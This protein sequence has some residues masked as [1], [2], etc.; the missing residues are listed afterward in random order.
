MLF[1]RDEIPSGARADCT[2]C[3]AGLYRNIPNSLD[4]SLALYISTVIFMAIANFYPFITM[5]TAGIKA[6]T[7]VV[8]GGYALYQFGMGELG[9]VV[10]LTSIIFPLVC[11]LGMIY[12]LLPARFGSLPPFYGPVYRIVHACEPWSLL[13]VFMLGTLIAAVKLRAL[14][15]V[16]PG[17]GMFGFVMMLLT[18]SAARA[19]FDPE[20][21]WSKCKVKQLNAN[22]FS[23]ETG[24]RVLNC[25]TCG[26]LREDHEHLHECERCGA[27]MH[28]R[29]TDSLQKTWAL[30]LAATVMLIPAQLFPVMSIKKLGKGGADTI[31]SGVIHLIEG[32]LY[33][34]AFIVLFASLVVPL[35]KLT[36][37][38]YLLYSVRNKSDW[39]PRDRTQLYR[40]TEIV[41][42]WSMVDVFLVGL[43]S[44]LVSLGLLASI[45]P[46]IGVTFFGAAVILTMLA[47]HSFDP[48]L[49]WDNTSLD[50]EGMPIK[51]VPKNENNIQATS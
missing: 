11:A 14:A 34:L 23:G 26:L 35:L 1:H 29:I 28:H 40:I 32:G 43:L 51:P 42:A 24:A 46:R 36:A 19:N 37:L 21:L 16:I 47:A 38:G 6:T 9:I 39:R 3:G 22:N 27:P 50:G 15:Q 7:Q 5:Q 30:L 17:L 44:G 48:R 33:G 12:L 45:E 2:R 4:R 49:I 25:H 31:M 20:S 18:Y 10:A 13:A 8:S 41:G